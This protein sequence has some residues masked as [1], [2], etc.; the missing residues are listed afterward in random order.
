MF[1]ILLISIVFSLITILCASDIDTLLDHYRI[2]TDLSRQTID[3]SQGFLTLYTRDDI[4]RMQ[5]RRLSDLLKTVR[6]YKYD[7]NMFGQTDMLHVDPISYMSDPIRVYLNDHE[8]YSGYVG[9][10]LFMYGDIDLGFIDHVEIYNGASSIE[11]NTEPALMIVKLYSRSA[12]RENGY[13]L[14]ATAGS[15]GSNMQNGAASYLFEDF[16]LFAY[17]NRTVRNREQY[18]HEAHTLSRDYDAAHLFANVESEH[19]R[20]DL[21]V[22]QKQAD[23]FLGAS[24]FA[25]PLPGDNDAWMARMALTSK[26]MDDSLVLDLSYWAGN[27]QSTFNSDG[28]LWSDNPADWF[29][30][31]DQLI[32]E[33]EDQVGSAKLS[34]SFSIGKHRLQTGM[35]W[36]HKSIRM[37]EQKRNGVSTLP[38]KTAYRSDIYSLYLQDRYLIDD[39][40]LLIA[41]LKVNHYDNDLY[42]AP[43]EKTTLQARLGYIYNVPGLRVKA[44]AEHSEFL[45]EQFLL[46]SSLANSDALIKT[47]T[48][49]FE[50]RY[51][52]GTQEVAFFATGGRVGS[53]NL[54]DSLQGIE[55]DGIA[56]GVNYRYAFDKFNKFEAQYFFNHFENNDYFSKG[57]GAFVRL[58]NTYGKWDIFNEAVFRVSDDVLKSDDARLTAMKSGVDYTAG[59]RYRFHPD[60]VISLKGTNIF[61]S[62]PR[63]RY[64]YVDDSIPLAPELDYL[65]I[66]PVDQEFTLGLEWRF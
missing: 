66:A 11:V 14:E 4:E 61:H 57:H 42:P 33:T 15:R 35:Q 19:H 38:G 3:E 7:E 41:A 29:L 17:V 18:T 13:R 6:F 50:T 60:A 28:T 9:S 65:Y 52:S 23:P 43:V 59:I 30:S 22:Y 47:D 49:S 2:D 54:S 36:R 53:E 51:G 16:S 39:S 8:I 55:Q 12:E 26:F 63:S 64:V 5:A 48:L 27:Y 10:G 46:I 20:L 21:E 25:T 37:L 1:R 40:Q 45:G 32:A 31:R 44:F 34:K 56:V 24:M 58:L 62:A